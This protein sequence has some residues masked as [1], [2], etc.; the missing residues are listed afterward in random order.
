MEELKNYYKRVAK[1]YSAASLLYWDMQTYMPKDAGPYRAEVLS[2]IGTYAFKSMIDD[3]LG[4]L[5]ETAQ[6]Q[7]EIEEKIVSVG[8]KEYYKYKKVPPELFQEIMMTSTMLEQKWEIAKPRGDFE[9]VRPLLEKLVELSRKYA[10]ILGYDE[11]PYDALLDLYEPGMRAMSVEQIFNNV[12]TFTLEVLKKIESLPKT[13]DPFDREISVEKQKE[14]S[15]WL[16]HYL[17]YDFNKGRLDVS[18]HPF[19]NP[20]GL[21]DVRITTRYIANDMR[22]SIYS[23]IHEFGH[24]LYALSI[25]AEFYG[26]PIGSSASYGFDESQSRFWENIVGRSLAFWKGIYQKFV[27]IV[28]EMKNYTVED[29]WRAV[30]RVQRSYIRTEADEVT[31]NLHIIIRF[32]IERALING[33]LSV[34]D[35]PEKWNELFKKYIGLEVP[36]NTLGCM[37]DPHW[38][39]GNFGYFPTYALGNLY[40][41]QI[42]EKLE[43]EIDFEDIVSKGEFYVIKDFLREKIHSKGKMYEPAELIK[44][45]TGKPLS[46]EPFVRYVKEKYSKVYG[47]EL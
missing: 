26:L 5:L 43:E 16:L 44:M 42:F 47:I 32:E 33:E 7:N 2:E 17:K 18:A 46:Y 1:Y 36:N 20:I 37:Q 35:I 25:P 38:Y 23:T 12:K 28:P 31:Y 34:K 19:T 21:N 13:E 9:E 39:G 4:T 22:N 24:A 30:N 8:K 45:V 10:E 6:P 11:E 3:A 41:A 14:F 27:E 40:A 15:T 29:I